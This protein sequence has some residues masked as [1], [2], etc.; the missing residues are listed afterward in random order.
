MT[1]SEDAPLHP[2]PAFSL[3]RAVARL[4]LPP[5][6]QAVYLRD[7]RTAPSTDELAL[8]FDYGY[9]MVNQ[10][11]RAGWLTSTE[12]GIL[13]EINALLT[14]MSGHANAPLWTVDA[15]TGPEW[16][17]VR[18]LARRYIRLGQPETK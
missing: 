7:L 1:G 2:Y 3:L 17:K 14:K 5:E 10:F 12:V 8:E 6:D 16:A 11:V 9:Q 18:D 15:L 4:A 13:Q